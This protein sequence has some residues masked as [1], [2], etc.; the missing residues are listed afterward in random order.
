M[1]CLSL[2]QLGNIDFVVSAFA[3]F[4]VVRIVEG[5]ADL[6]S[7]DDHLPNEQV[8]QS[9]IFFTVLERGIPFEFF[10]V[11]TREREKPRFTATAVT[12][13]PFCIHKPLSFS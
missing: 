2:F 9:A 8:Y 6:V 3:F 13:V 4:V 10:Q 11:V 12:D 1:L 7:E 5:D